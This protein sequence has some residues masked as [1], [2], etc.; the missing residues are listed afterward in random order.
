MELPITVSSKLSLDVHNKQLA[1]L[2]QIK[3]L[4]PNKMRIN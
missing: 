3:F 2:K 1:S 4:V